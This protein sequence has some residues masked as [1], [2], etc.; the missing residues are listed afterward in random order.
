MGGKASK[1]TLKAAA[2]EQRGV[3]VPAAS[4][5]AVAC[6]KVATSP[7]APD[8]SPGAAATS[9]TGDVSEP[10]AVVLPDARAHTEPS[11]DTDTTKATEGAPLEPTESMNETSAVNTT[12]TAANTTKKTKK[13]KMEKGPKVPKPLKRVHNACPILPYA[14]QSS[15]LTPH[16]SHLTPVAEGGRREQSAQQ[17]AQVV[18]RGCG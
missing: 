14:V 16:T 5:A 3:P 11:K 9:S 2:P 4:V 7:D 13:T 15:H 1:K 8:M 12:S 10:V 17:E 6:S 18:G